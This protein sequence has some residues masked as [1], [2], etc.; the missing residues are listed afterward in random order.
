MAID[1]P[2]NA[3]AAL[4]TLGRLSLR[5]LS[6]DDLLST[7]AGLA[8]AVLPG[9]PEASVTLLVRDRPTTVV[10]TG[11]LALDL[12][13]SQY[14]QD[15]GPCLHAA[16]SGELTEI[17]D[18]RTDPRWPDHGRRAAERG[19]L[20]SLSIPLA[21]DDDV[22]GA[23]NVYAR[24]AAAFDDAAR[25]AATGFGSYAAVAA[26]NLHAYQRARSQAD[27]LQAALESR[28]VIDQAKGILMERYRLTAD[29]AFQLLTKASMGT[30]RKLRTIADE[31]VHTGELPAGSGDGA[32]RRPRSGR[33]ASRAPGDS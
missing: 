12:D 4:E 7:V 30:N 10:H 24:R 22:A 32:G 3:A 8:R 31:L 21:V 28:A 29:Q 26:G 13:E 33:P 6:M 1:P 2:A 5:E 16:R 14:Q 15:Q 17:T 19:S 23:L 18:T 25:A 20:S 27:D 9:E 11:P